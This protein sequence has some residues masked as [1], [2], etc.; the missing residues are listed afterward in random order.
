M[1]G[2]F[3][4][5]NEDT[6]FARALP[7][8]YV[9]A[10]SGCWEWVGATTYGYGRWAP[11]G[12]RMQGAHR[13]MYERECGPIPEGMTIDHLCRNR[14]CVNPDHMEVVSNVENVMRGESPPARNARRTHCAKGHPY[15]P[16]NVYVH[17][18][19]SARP[20]R[21]ICRKCRHDN[22]RK[23]RAARALIGGRG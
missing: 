3:V 11:D 16:D 17:P 22:Q 13:V 18:P 6:M 1:I 21:R 8:G 14:R 4:Q 9:I 15:T 20:G 12:N 5:L 10:E 7:I 23:R 2:V 19:H